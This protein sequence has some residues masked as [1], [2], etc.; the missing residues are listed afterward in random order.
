MK[1]RSTQ[2]KE[3]CNTY[4]KM[5]ALQNAV[6]LKVGDP[7]KGYKKPNAIKACKHFNN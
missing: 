3:K 1:E 4:H 5:S 2:A 7:Q 6:C